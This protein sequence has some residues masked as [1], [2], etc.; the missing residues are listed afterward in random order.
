MNLENL[1]TKQKEA[2]QNISGPALILAGAGTGKTTVLTSRIA[3]MIEQNIPPHNILAITFTN[4]AANEMK[5]RVCQLLPQFYRNDFFISTFHSFCLSVIK[6]YYKKLGLFDNFTIFDPS[7][8][9]KL[10]REVLSEL[11]LEEYNTDIKLI[12]SLISK[13]KNK[14]ILP[15]N[16]Q[17]EK[18]YNAIPIDRIYELYQ[19][20]LKIMNSVD[21][22]DLIFYVYKLWKKFPEILDEYQEIFKYV[23]V[24]EFQDTNFAQI[25]L[26]KL[27]VNKYNN[28]FVVGDDDQ[29]IYAWRGAEI[30]NI[31]EFEH[32]FEHTTIIKLEHNYR[33]TNRILNA[34]NK[35][36]DKNVNRYKK[37]LYS[38]NGDGELLNVYENQSS[39]DEARELVDI[40]QQTLEGEKYSPKDIAIIYRMNTQSRYIEE[41]L[42]KQQIPYNIIAD[43]SFFERKEIRDTIAY[44][45][46]LLNPYNEIA[47]SRII[48]TPSRNIGKTSLDK[49]RNFAHANNKTLLKSLQDQELLKILPSKTRESCFNF[50]D[51]I[52]YYHQELKKNKKKF[53]HLIRNYLNE[54]S[55]LSQLHKVFR[56]PKDEESRRNNILEFIHSIEEYE[57]DLEEENKSLQNFMDKINLREQNRKNQ[58]EKLLETVTLGTIHALKGLEY[59]FVLII[60]LEEG[61]FPSQRSLDEGQEEEERRL[62]YVAITRAK[63]QL[64]FSWSKEKNLYNKII[65]NVKSRFLSELPLEDIEFLNEKK[66]STINRMSPK[67]KAQHDDIMEQIYQKFPNLRSKEN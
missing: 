48:A 18:T 49:A 60:G 12:I 58:K 63:E 50:S 39:K 6:K 23:L 9:Q 24:D 4:K 37:N 44:I 35:I 54:I 11:Y 22:D 31:L 65:E 3:Y 53:S 21:F 43:Q 19:S 62:F 17:N 64:I 5:Q 46:L 67:K 33:S 34:A 2:V 28:I 32:N 10:I 14:L 15:K 7:D 25:E 57:N 42:I 45:Q 26:I 52:L 13:A 47:L 55:F 66:K 30:S 1:N 56:D 8:Q 29:S 16:Y 38:E 20:R 40:I 61:S 27:L 41:Q 59:P 51:L 36:I